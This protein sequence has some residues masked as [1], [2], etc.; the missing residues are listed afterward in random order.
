MKEVKYENT[1]ALA[2]SDPSCLL[3][4]FYILI[5]LSSSSS[6]S[7]STSPFLLST[8]SSPSSSSFLLSCLQVDAGTAAMLQG[9]ALA[10]RALGLH[11]FKGV[12]EPISVV[13]IG[14]AEFAP[15]LSILRCEVP[16]P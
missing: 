1:G 16:V 12:Q 8:S 7:P 6:L 10:T 4:A 3:G 9:S 2:G 5:R 11:T 13:Q 15:I 14:A